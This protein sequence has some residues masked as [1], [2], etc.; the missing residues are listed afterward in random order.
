MGQWGFVFPCTIAQAPIFALC[1]VFWLQSTQSQGE[2]A[3][4][5]RRL[6]GGA[7]VTLAVLLFARLIC[8]CTSGFQADE[9]ERQYM[10]ITGGSQCNWSLAR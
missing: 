6:V 9:W 2:D 10:G 4:L 1:L 8:A 5:A 3:L 7:C